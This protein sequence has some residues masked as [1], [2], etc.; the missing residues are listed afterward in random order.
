MFGFARVVGRS[1]EPTLHAGDRLVVRYGCDV[2]P[3]DVVV[4]RFVDG[5]LAVKRA[6]EVRIDRR[7]EPGWWVLSDN[8]A[9]GIDSRHRGVVPS[10]DVL[11]RVLCRV[12]PSPRT[13]R[14][15]AAPGADA[16][17]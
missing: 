10:A 11:A 16:R 8:P 15:L 9:E 2:R 12:W 5:T 14:G 6:V 13:A 4:V 1:M 7:G 3:G 17:T